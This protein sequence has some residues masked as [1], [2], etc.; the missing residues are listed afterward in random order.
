MVKCLTQWFNTICIISFTAPPP[1]LHYIPP[2]YWEFSEG[3]VGVVVC[4]YVRVFHAWLS[5]VR[6]SVLS[7]WISLC[8]LSSAVRVT[9]THGPPTAIHLSHHPS[10]SL[11]APIQS[12]FPLSHLRNSWK[13]SAPIWVS[14]S[15]ERLRVN[16]HRSSCRG[17]HLWVSEQLKE[18]CC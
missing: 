10:L 18:H 3:G 6:T 14:C 7:V 15:L 12:S 2:E 16:C 5:C 9:N 8:N 17:G 13:T 4:F 11:S 1:P